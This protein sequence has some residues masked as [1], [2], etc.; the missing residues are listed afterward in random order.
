MAITFEDIQVLVDQQL[1]TERKITPKELIEFLVNGEH[2]NDGTILFI[3]ADLVPKFMETFPASDGHVPSE[4]GDGMLS[5]L[6]GIPVVTDL[7]VHG[8][9]RWST[10]I[11]IFTAKQVMELNVIK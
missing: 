9:L 2:L 3:P 10:E 8:A 5:T 4:A 7:F 1:V 6:L 11:R